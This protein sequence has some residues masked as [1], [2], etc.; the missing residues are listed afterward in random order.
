M[1]WILQYTSNIDVEVVVDNYVEHAFLFLFFWIAE[2]LL[3]IKYQ[4]WFS[5]CKE[6]KRF[7]GRSEEQ[8]NQCNVILI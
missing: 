8:L 1:F 4:F 3:P 2:N 6:E 7:Q 5:H